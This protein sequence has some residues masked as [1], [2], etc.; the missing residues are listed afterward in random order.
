MSHYEQ[1]FAEADKDG[2]GFLTLAELTHM[3]RSKG[4]KETDDKIKAMFISVDASGD[5]KISKEEYLTTMGEMPPKNHQEARMRQC[6]REFDRDGSGSIEASELKE[7]M[8][9]SG[10]NLSDT[11]VARLVQIV[12]KDGSGTV[13]YEEFIA[14]VFGK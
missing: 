9:K 12:D 2:S 7:V 8:N 11:E 5:N 10:S 1:F 4:Y 14:H 3:L 13:S 6:F